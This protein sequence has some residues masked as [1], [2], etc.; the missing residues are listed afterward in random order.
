MGANKAI[1]YSRSITFGIARTAEYAIGGGLE[2]GT[3]GW[4]L[5]VFSFANLP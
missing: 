1:A 4:S 5:K 3:L 2:F